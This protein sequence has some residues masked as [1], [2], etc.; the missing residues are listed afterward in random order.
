MYALLMSILNL[1]SMLSFQFGGILMWTLGVTETNFERLWILI[2]VVNL[3]VLLPIPLVLNI[4]I[5]AAQN[6]AEKF[7][8]NENKDTFSDSDEIN[9]FD[10]DEDI[11]IR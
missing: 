6:I 11:L 10:Y 4:E 1:G 5:G 8:I 3:I 2:L 9:I 7:K